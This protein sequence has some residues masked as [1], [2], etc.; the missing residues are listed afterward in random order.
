MRRRRH[1]TVLLLLLLLLLLLH[2]TKDTHRMIESQ[3]LGGES[4]MCHVTLGVPRY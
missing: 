2:P 4:I 3:W 1:D